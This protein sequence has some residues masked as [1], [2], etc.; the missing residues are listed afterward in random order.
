[1]H[2]GG[3][4]WVRKNGDGKLGWGENLLTKREEGVW[5]QT[6]KSKDVFSTILIVKIAKVVIGIIAP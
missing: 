6:N 5:G 2:D 4:V 3:V 1:M